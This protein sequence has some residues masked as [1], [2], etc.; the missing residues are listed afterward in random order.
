MRL[1]DAFFLCWKSDTSSRPFPRTL[2]KTKTSVHV[3]AG[4]ATSGSD[5]VKTRARCGALLLQLCQPTCTGCKT[6]AFLNAVCHKRIYTLELRAANVINYCRI[7][8]N[9]FRR[10]T[11]LQFLFLLQCSNDDVGKEM[12]LKKRKN[13]FGSQPSDFW[14]TARTKADR[15]Q[16]RTSA[17]TK[18]SRTDSWATWKMQVK[19]KSKDCFKK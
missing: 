4:G 3:W 6:L 8:F 17:T 1:S 15:N 2:S 9:V 13:I 10:R 12:L 19:A 11:S 7:S 18:F 16:S 14:C 5:G